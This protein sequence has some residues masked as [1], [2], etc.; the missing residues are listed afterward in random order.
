MIKGLQQKE[1]NWKPVYAFYTQVSHATRHDLAPPD[2]GVLRESHDSVGSNDAKRF[3]GRRHSHHN[4]GRL[5]SLT[6][7]VLVGA[8]RSNAHRFGEAAGF[9]CVVMQNTDAED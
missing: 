9:A 7:I 8:L 4:A 6:S 3:N 2:S 5:E 1:V